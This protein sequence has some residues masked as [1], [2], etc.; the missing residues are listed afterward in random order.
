M[1][2]NDK[3]RNSIRHFIIWDLI[4]HMAKVVLWLITSLVAGCSCL[5]LVLIQISSSWCSATTSKIHLGFS[6]VL[7][8][9]ARKAAWIS[10][11]FYLGT[12]N[13][14]VNLNVQ[15]HGEF[16]DQKPFVGIRPVCVLFWQTPFLLSIFVNGLTCQSVLCKVK[17]SQPCGA[18]CSG[19]EVPYISST[20]T[21]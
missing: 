4:S 13:W 17:W 14:H 15:W 8:F 2:F 3:L 11:R 9:W 20:S 1:I 12:S 7:Q 19:A 6:N 18:K 16:T 10:V 5:S 21:L